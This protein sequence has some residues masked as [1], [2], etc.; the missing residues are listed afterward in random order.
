MAARAS[1]FQ[2]HTAVAGAVRSLEWRESTAGSSPN[3]KRHS[4]DQAPV[5]LTLTWTV[6]A[7]ITSP[8]AGV[9]MVSLAA[10]PGREEVE[11]PGGPLAAWPLP[12]HAA[13][14]KTTATATRETLTSLIAPPP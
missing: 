6:R 11:G 2:D 7:W 4:S 3:R 13:A 9:M 12:P 10:L 5:S 1:L 8:L 14:D